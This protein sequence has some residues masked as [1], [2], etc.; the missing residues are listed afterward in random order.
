MEVFHS[1]HGRV[2]QQD[3]C[4]LIFIRYFIYDPK[5]AEY[6][7]WQVCSPVSLSFSI[8]L[9]IQLSTPCA[10]TGVDTRNS[11][12]IATSPDKVVTLCRF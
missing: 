2:C 7:G 4:V 6:T 8:V 3:I 11:V 9:Y 12:A 1:I 10:A 5:R